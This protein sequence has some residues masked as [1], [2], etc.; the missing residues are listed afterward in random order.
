MGYGKLGKGKG[1]FSGEGQE[2]LKE[3]LTKKH[4][5]ILLS[6]NA[7][8]PQNFIDYVTKTKELQM[9]A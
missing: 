4:S 1:I 8:A 3:E 2:A 6:Q 9:V 7:N 5:K